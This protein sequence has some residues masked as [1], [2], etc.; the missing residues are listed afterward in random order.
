MTLIVRNLAC[1]V[2]LLFLSASA[3][4][5][6]T[7][8]PKPPNFD[9]VS[10]RPNNTGS[11][12]ISVSIDEDHFEMT[13]VTFAI[14]LRNAFDMKPAQIL[15][16]PGWAESQH[17]DVKGKVIDGDIEALKKMTDEERRPMFQAMI[18]ER[19]GLQFHMSTKDMSVYELVVAKG[20]PKM[21][22]LPP[23][24]DAEKEAE[25]GSD[26]M[27]RGSV[28]MNRD[29]EGAHLTTVGITMAR[30][31]SVL[32]DR[33][34][35][36]VLDKTNLTGDYTVELRWSP[37]DAAPHPD[38]PAN[39]LP[40]LFTALQEELGLRMVSTHGDVPTMVVDHVDRPSEN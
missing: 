17:F 1:A 20:G 4:C 23:Q 7:P 40:S 10:I 38:S 18:Q 26:K 14:M 5:A 27:S 16:L 22:A 24:T 3:I 30:L 35:R 21:K 34:G 32:S 12:S 25:R 8:H 36:P 15:N 2:S 33:A 13:N 9:V 11:G 28:N 31:A 6:Q 37:E 19:F 29:A 39:Q